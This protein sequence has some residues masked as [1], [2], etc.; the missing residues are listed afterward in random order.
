MTDDELLQGLGEIRDLM[1]AVAT[2]GPRINDV[3]GRYQ[4]LYAEVSR[5]LHAAA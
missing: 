3:N 4:R 5:T 1:I 2:G